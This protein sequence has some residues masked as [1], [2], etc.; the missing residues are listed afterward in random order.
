MEK[1]THKADLRP[2]VIKPTDEQ[3]WFS[4]TRF[5]PITDDF[6]YHEDY[7]VI[8][9]PF[10]VVW[11]APV[12]ARSLKSL[13]EHIRYIQDNQIEKAY[14]VA[15]DIS[16]LR[17]CPSLKS[18]RIIP[19]YSASTF[20]Y[21]PLYDM[22]NLEELSCQT[23]Y[24]AKDALKTN[25]DY[26]RFAHLQKL[27]AFGAKGHSNLVSVKGLRTL[28]LGQGQPVSKTLK[29]FDFSELKELDICQSPIHS[30][31]GIET[32]H[33]LQKLCLSY[34]RSLE[35]LAALADIGETLTSLEIESCGK[36]KD[37]SWLQ[38]LPNLENLVLFGSNSISD[39]SFLKNMKKLKSL[40]FTMNIQDGDLELCKRIPYVYC[41]NKKHYNFKN[42]DLPKGENS[43]DT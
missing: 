41:K 38:R 43:M 8:L 26:S 6:Y 27:I 3:P 25:I 30:L 35:N 33:H 40:R 12:L 21:A 5:S 11:E 32:A 10:N 14:V 31:D 1:A 23:I 4:M 19:A 13:D 9:S 17:E 15:E 2:Y 34:C 7:L 42:D 24:G 20:D 29:A 22:P 28:Y 37:F 18:L 36:I 16:F 39:L